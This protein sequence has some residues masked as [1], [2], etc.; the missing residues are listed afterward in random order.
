MNTLQAIVLGL[1]Q[2]LAE[3]LPISSSGHLILTRAIMGISDEASA[4]GA[5]MM[6]DVLLHAGI[7]ALALHSGNA[8]AQ[9]SDD[10]VTHSLRLFGDDLAP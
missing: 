1:V 9:L 2:G 4:T 5:Y 8:V 7:H 10:G 6:L 3:F